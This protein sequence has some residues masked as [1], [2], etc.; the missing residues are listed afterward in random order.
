MSILNLK[1]AVETSVAEENWYA[2]LAL[3]LALPDICGKLENPVITSQKR[4][5]A[6]FDKYLLKIYTLSLFG[7]TT[8]FLN[9]SDLYALRCALLHEGSEDISSQRAKQ[10]LDTFIFSIEESHQLLINNTIL[11]LNV[12]KFCQEVC[13]AVEEWFNDVKN[14]VD[15]MNRIN[16]MLTIR[17]LHYSPTP[18]IIIGGRS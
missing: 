18:G 13:V 5:I 6:W 9:G 16:S 2:A 12:T 3:A 8:V 11:I 14:D 10:T 17:G 15:I 4:Y 1:E 7:N